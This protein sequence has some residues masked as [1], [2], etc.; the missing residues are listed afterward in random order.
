M[1]AEQP[2]DRYLSPGTK[3]R[4]DCLWNGVTPS[5]EYGV[6]VHCW[7]S[8]DLGGLHDCI[9][10]FFGNSPPPVGQPEDKPYV[11]RYAVVSLTILEAWP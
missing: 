11:L 8:E 3:V 10:A 2:V 4:Y 7:P 6:V 5:S 1:I 9:V